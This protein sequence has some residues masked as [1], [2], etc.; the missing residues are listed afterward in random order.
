MPALVMGFSVY[1]VAKAFCNLA[2]RGWSAGEALRLA[3]LWAEDQAELGLMRVAPQDAHRE[4]VFECEPRPGRLYLT[5]RH[6][7]Y[8][9]LFRVLAKASH[10]DTVLCLAGQVGGNIR[11]AT[12]ALA[13][14]AGC[15]VDFVTVSAAG[16]RAV[17]EQLRQGC[18]AVMLIDAPLRT[19]TRGDD[20]PISTPLGTY[21]A[22]A[23]L[24]RLPGLIDPAFAGLC[25]ERR[26]GRDV[27]GAMGEEG[28]FASVIAALARRIVDRPA[29]YELLPDLHKQWS[30]A[31][32]CDIAAT[33]LHDGARMVLHARSMRTWK[34][35]NSGSLALE[36]G[37]TAPAGL[38]QALSAKLDVTIDDLFAL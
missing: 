27:I 36:P 28:D 2:G 32:P 34:L 30:A 6:G 15:N 17:R 8:P 35:A 23:A 25:C 12:Q 4:V 18:S 29:H 16:I 20:I 11:M 24:T 31:H 5:A 33:F 21:G 3:G 1:S 38:C 19:A 26:E 9:Q 13:R 10:R 37:E 22:T 7:C 14:F